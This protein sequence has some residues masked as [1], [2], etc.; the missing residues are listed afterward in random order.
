M[1]RGC[2]LR[3]GGNR[4]Q[5]PR[6]L[7]IA[8]TPALHKAALGGPF[9][10]CF[11]HVQFQDEFGTLSDTAGPVG[12][13]DDTCSA[14]LPNLRTSHTHQTRPVPVLLLQRYDDNHVIVSLDALHCVGSVSATLADA[15]I[16]RRPSSSS[17][18]CCMAAACWSHH[19][20]S[21]AVQVRDRQRRHR[22]RA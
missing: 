8:P 14:S 7:V 20:L 6:A 3:A 19:S 16:I 18:R 15:D 2:P 22:H 21:V 17:S 4:I 10:T 12:A 1:Y 9:V 13:L 11:C 5:Q